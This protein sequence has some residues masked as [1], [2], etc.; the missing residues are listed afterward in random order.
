MK[1]VILKVPVKDVV[2]AS[3][4]H[5]HCEEGDKV[6]K[7]QDLVEINCDGVSYHIPSPASGTLAEVFF[8]SG[9]VVDIGEVI[10]EIED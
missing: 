2:E 3:I 7:G 5:W 1:E 6:E 8:E 10:A 9:E 4:A